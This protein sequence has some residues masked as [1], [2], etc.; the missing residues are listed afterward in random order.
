MRP[1]VLF[2][3]CSLDGYI[4]RSD[5]G[6]DWLFTDQDYGYQEF[7]A[8]V[9]TLL[10]GRR[11][12]EVSLTFGENVYENRE[13]YV[14]TRTPRPRHGNFTFVTQDVTSFVSALKRSPG[15]NIWLVGGGE[16]AAEFMRRNLID[17]Y[18]LFIHPIVLGQGIPLVSAGV[19][20]TRLEFVDSK[21]FGTGL[22]QLNYRRPQTPIDE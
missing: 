16:I 13:S 20:E 15:S 5:G 17:D 22:V 12:F 6:I 19:P 9:D 7:F 2:I 8:S 10:M 18:R 11:T 14:F 3:A 21:T 1:V 4:A